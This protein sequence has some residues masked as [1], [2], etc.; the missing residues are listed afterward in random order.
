MPNQA[1]I[2]GYVMHN[3]TYF[4]NLILD[5]SSVIFLFHSINVFNSACNFS[6]LAS[7]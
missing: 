7:L 3:L 4:D 5:G 2:G 1:L 6:S